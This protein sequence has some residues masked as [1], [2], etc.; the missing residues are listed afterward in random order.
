[1]K[2]ANL[3]TKL[4]MAAVIL[5]VLCYFCINLTAFF[6]DPFS[7][8]VAYSYTNNHA[9]TVSGYVVRDEAPIEGAGDLVYFSRGEGERVSKGGSV[10]LVY[11]NRQV[12]D[13]A[14][15]VR[16]LEEQLAQLRYAK[17]LASGVYST[18][19]LDK[20]VNEALSTF[21]ASRTRN[22]I[23]SSIDAAAALRSAVLRYSYAYSGTGDLDSSITAMENR[24]AELTASI[25]GSTTSI[26]A[27]S[28]GLFSSLVDG[29]ESVLTPEVL[30]TMTV[31]DYRGITPAPAS[32]MGKLVYGSRWYFV[33]LLRESDAKG[34]SAGQMVTLR[35]QSGLDRDLSLTVDRVSNARGGQ[36]LVV[37]SSDQNL[38]LITLLRRQNAQLIF[39]SYTGLRVPRSAVRIVWETVKDEQGN[40]VMNADGTEKKTQ[41]YGVYTRWGNSARFKKVEILWQEDEYMLVRSL[42]ENDAARRLRAGDEVITAAEDLY[43]GKVIE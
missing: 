21:H 30:M 43:D 14:N 40:P 35:F 27:T 12:L 11:E 8:T 28:S 42:Q 16:N 1:M 36:V 6:S 31:D 9:V 26:R 19:A 32:G 2:N 3:S 33:T 23:N 18:V 13:D 24:I 37:L 4:L 22:H 10:A 7:T 17:S 25:S 29:Y 20:N 39:E 38:N 5:T 41:V 15:T 34:I